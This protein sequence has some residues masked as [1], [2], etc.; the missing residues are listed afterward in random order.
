MRSPPK[1]S[2]SQPSAMPVPEPEQFSLLSGNLVGDGFASDCILRH[3]V[4][5]HSGQILARFTSPDSGFH[6]DSQPSHGVGLRKW[7]K[8]MISS[9]GPPY[10]IEILLVFLPRRNSGKAKPVVK[11]VPR[12]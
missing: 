6:P 8:T 11:S 7:W 1:K 4:E 12:K 10:W 5:D 9:A 3:G 2:E